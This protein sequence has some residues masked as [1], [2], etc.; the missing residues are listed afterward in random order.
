MNWRMQE[1][2]IQAAYSITY[3]ARN[4]I[5][6]SRSLAL[7]VSMCLFM[8]FTAMNAVNPASVSQEHFSTMLSLAR[9]LYIDCNATENYIL[10]VELYAIMYDVNIILNRGYGSDFELECRMQSW[11]AQLSRYEGGL[12]MDFKSRIGALRCRFLFMQLQIV[13]E[14]Y[15]YGPHVNRE[16]LE[17]RLSRVIAIHEINESNTR[18]QDN[19]NISTRP[20]W[21]LEIMIIPSV[22]WVAWYWR[23][24]SVYVRIRRL[25][26]DYAEQ[27]QP[28]QMKLVE[29]VLEF[30]MELVNTPYDKPTHVELEL[31][32]YKPKVVQHYQSYR[33]IDHLL[34]KSGISNG[35]R[36][37]IPDRPQIAQE[38]R[39]R[40]IPRTI[41]NV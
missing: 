2:L 31:F 11:L 33:Y 7:L 35:G 41:T 30:V 26:S 4:T 36:A 38:D 10:R 16:S 18:N 28:E 1:G 19:R 23:A 40:T 14:T 13:W 24:P 27:S 20:S 6:K 15:L 5:R 39:F 12:P 29:V 8:D 17:S 37:S 3:S 32:G 9:Q 22:I 21:S 34:W 25:L